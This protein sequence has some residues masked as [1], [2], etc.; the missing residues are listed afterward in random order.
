MK[1][2]YFLLLNNFVEPCGLTCVVIDNHKV[3]SSTVRTVV[4]AIHCDVRRIVACSSIR[5]YCDSY[6]T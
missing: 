6:M 5:F 1:I 4:Y 2:F 3:D